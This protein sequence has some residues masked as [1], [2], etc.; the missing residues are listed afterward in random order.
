MKYFIFNYD[1]ISKTVTPFG[2]A[3]EKLII[4]NNYNGL[5]NEALKSINLLNII[6]NDNNYKF[7]IGTQAI[8]ALPILN[9]SQAITEMN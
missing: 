4:Y 9:T 8:A 3:T 6:G 2:L 1:M 5:N 7:I